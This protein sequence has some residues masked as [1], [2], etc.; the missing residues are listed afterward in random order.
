MVHVKKVAYYAI[1]LLPARGV[2]LLVD[3][4]VPYIQQVAQSLPK[5]S[6]ILDTEKQTQGCINYQRKQCS[7]NEKP[8]FRIQNII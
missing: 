3:V 4:P 1:P 5:I 7:N 2:N 6:S 8:I